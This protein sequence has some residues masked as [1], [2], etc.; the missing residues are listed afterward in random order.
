MNWR[1]TASVAL[2][3]NIL[4]NFGFATDTQQGIVP[5]IRQNVELVNQ[6]KAETQVLFEV[7]TSTI[8]GW[9]GITVGGLF[10]L[11]TPVEGQAS[12]TVAAILPTPEE[13][14]MFADLLA[15]DREGSKGYATDVL[16]Y[17]VKDTLYFSAANTALT[18]LL[19]KLKFFNLS[20]EE[21]M[22]AY[23]RFEEHPKFDE[24]TRIYTDS[25]GM[26]VQEQALERSGDLQSQIVIEVV[27]KLLEERD[28]TSSVPS[29]HA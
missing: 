17:G 27:T 16:I 13:P 10:G 29:L 22:L 24:L 1:R 12:G 4:G 15:A 6:P 21:R 9:S 20:M 11:H 5:T 3:L 26:P 14:F 2:A 28:E 7:D 8:E 23:E 19:R 18:S 25:R